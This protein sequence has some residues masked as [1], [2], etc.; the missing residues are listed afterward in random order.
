MNSKDTALTFGTGFD[1]PV[2]DSQKTFRVLLDAMA[3][4]GVI[5]RFPSL[6]QAPAPLTPASAAV[7]LT[8][9][10]MDTPLWLD[11]PANVPPVVD[12]LRFG[13]GCSLARDP[14]MAAFGLISDPDSM[15]PLSSFPQGTAEYPDR[16]AS[17]IIQ[18][19][20]LSK[21]KGKTL[22]GPGIKERTQLKAEGLPERVWEQM[23]DFKNLFPLGVDI[24]LVT[25]DSL[26]CL[27]RTVLVE[28]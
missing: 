2:L 10:D 4:P 25:P 28:D 13:T 9:L 24:V 22:R 18:V 12:F 19:Q 17:L 8:L 20:G 6:P 14:G 16:S 7:C 5:H 21:Q 1:D 26:A 11:D 23:K 27:P 15:P 3:R